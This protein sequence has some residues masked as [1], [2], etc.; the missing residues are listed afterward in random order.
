MCVPYAMQPLPSL[1]AP[2]NALSLV[3]HVGSMGGQLVCLLHQ[4]HESSMGWSTHVV[5]HTSYSTHNTAMLTGL[6]WGMLRCQVDSITICRA[7]VMGA[8]VE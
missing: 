7:A 4:V 3:P 5:L 8:H 1:L 6:H 2:A